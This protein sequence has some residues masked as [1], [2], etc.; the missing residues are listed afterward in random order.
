M[1]QSWLILSILTGIFFGIQSIL[2]KF[3]SRDFEQSTI[4]KY[5]FLTAGILL[6]PVAYHEPVQL[7][8]MHFLFAFSL[9]LIL[10]IIAYSL[11]LKAIST[12]PISIVMP[13]VGLTPL[14]LTL[15]SYLILGEAITEIKFVGIFLIVIGGFILQL[16]TTAA[17]S[18]KKGSLLKRLI[19]TGDKGIWYMIL[20][21]FIWS[22]TASVEKIAVRSS[23]PAFYGAGIHLSLGFSFL[24]IERLMRLN[25]K[26]AVPLSKI[27]PIK[28]KVYLVFLGLV[29][30]ALAI[31][32]L[33]AIKLA[34]VTYV[35]TFKRA[36]VL[37][38]T[39]LAFLFFNEKNYL[40]SITGTIFILLGSAI[41]T[42]L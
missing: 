3:L 38:S 7:E 20:V 22:I 35:I 19:N 28:A 2:L 33:T 21:A 8:F 26:K 31:C 24:F 25:K 14:F 11:L 13:F 17:P 32:Q 36:G 34:F 39:L 29:S 37:V 30:A 10:N 9:S 42:L 15:T 1:P 6:I 23:S 5:L 18:T 12:Y 4:L 16:P 40:K 41:I 27:P